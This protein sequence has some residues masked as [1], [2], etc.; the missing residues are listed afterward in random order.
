MGGQT[1]GCLNISVCKFAHQPVVK[2]SLRSGLRRHCHFLLCG[3]KSYF[4]NFQSS[5]QEASESAL[6]TN[7]KWKAEKTDKF[8]TLLWSVS[9]VTGQTTATKGERQRTTLVGSEDPAGTGTRVGTLNCGWLAGGSVWTVRETK[10]HG[11]SHRGPSAFM[12]FTSRSSM[13]PSQWT[14]DKNPFVLL[15]GGGEKELHSSWRDLFTGETGY[16]KPA[17]LGY[18]Q[19]LTDLRERSPQCEPLWGPVS[20]NGAG[21]PRTETYS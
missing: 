11:S 15:A 9:E 12:S 2:G 16:T 8:A 10:H 14:S 4:C 5:T 21:A 6:H 19:S 3:A 7:N 18:C 1:D 20:P 17:L 13:K